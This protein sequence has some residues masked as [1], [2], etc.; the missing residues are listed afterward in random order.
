VSA[1]RIK[2]GKDDTGYYKNQIAIARFYMSH[3]AS[4]A[5]SLARTVAQGGPIVAG[6]ADDG[7]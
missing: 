1:Q 7:F 3:I 6:F 2:E 5:E 4:G